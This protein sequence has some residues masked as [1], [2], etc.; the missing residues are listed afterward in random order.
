MQTGLDILIIASET[1]NH[2]SLHMPK[3]LF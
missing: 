1:P 3:M 2:T